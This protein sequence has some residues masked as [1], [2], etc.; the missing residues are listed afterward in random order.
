MTATRPRGWPN[1]RIR[2]LFIPGASSEYFRGR[3]DNTATRVVRIRAVALLRDIVRRRRLPSPRAL[4][5]RKRAIYASFERDQSARRSRSA[6]APLNELREYE[7]GD[8]VR[9]N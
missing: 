3:R 9:V 5:R 4:P 6:P 1:F 7:E 8:A 2:E